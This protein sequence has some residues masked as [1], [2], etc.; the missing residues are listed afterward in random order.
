[1][2]GLRDM[3]HDPAK[4]AYVGTITSIRK[5]IY[6]ITAGWMAIAAFYLAAGGM[7][8]GTLAFV[9][10]VLFMAT[11]FGALGIFLALFKLPAALIY[12]YV[13]HP[14]SV[15]TLGHFLCYDYATREIVVL[16][17]NDEIRV[18]IDMLEDFKHNEDTSGSVTM[19]FKP[20]TNPQI[21]ETL[22]AMG[23]RLSP[24]KFTEVFN[25]LREEALK[26]A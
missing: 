18:P 14:K 6:G 13:L 20:E 1:M 17:G 16:C 9:G 2:S 19:T 23:L 5:Y 15:K 26:S 7:L 3:N 24:K 8:V 21:C 10:L 12:A 22:E 11:P 25:I 4:G